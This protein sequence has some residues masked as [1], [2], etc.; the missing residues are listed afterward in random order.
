VVVVDSVSRTIFI[1]DPDNGKLFRFLECA[2]FLI[3]PSDIAVCKDDFYICD[4]KVK[5]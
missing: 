5:S 3:E 1:V 4:F 2:N